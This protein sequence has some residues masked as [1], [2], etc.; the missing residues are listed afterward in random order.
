LNSRAH[1]ALALK[2]TLSYSEGE[3]RST[4]GGTDP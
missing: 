3:V 2:R 1:F 4:V